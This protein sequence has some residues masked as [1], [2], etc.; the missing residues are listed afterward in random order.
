MRCFT[1]RKEIH[2]GKNYLE[3][4][5]YPYTERQ[6]DAVKKRRGKR[7]RV[8]SPKQRNLN[9]KNA[10]RYLTQLANT[11]FD[12]SGYHITATY[13]PKYLPQSIEDAGREIRNYLRRVEERRK[14]AGLE[15]LKYILVTECKTDKGG[16]KPVRIHHHILMNGGLPRETLESIWSR[17]RRKGQK[18]GERLGFINADKLQPQDNGLEALCAYLTKNPNGKK[19][20]S[21]SKNLEH[22]WFTTNDSEFSRRKVE[23]IAKAPPDG[24]IWEKRYHG[25]RVVDYKAEF[26][27]I[28]GW[29]LSVKM[30]KIAEGG[31]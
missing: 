16:E 3:I 7:Q 9:D 6:G 5:V 27:E 17:P 2:C 15:P 8:T 14:K 30:R 26:N 12:E 1:R 31:L 21:S 4:D 25:F 28:T 22:P 23:K 11:N 13:S 29:S 19:R 24:S 18:Q 10:R 20:W